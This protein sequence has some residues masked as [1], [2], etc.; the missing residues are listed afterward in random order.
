MVPTGHHQAF[1]ASY[2]AYGMVNTN[3]NTNTT[4]KNTTTTH[5]YTGQQL[6]FMKFTILS[7]L[8]GWW[9]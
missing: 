5:C 3:T 1:L 8:T 4:K 9:S 6:P 2:V 7:V